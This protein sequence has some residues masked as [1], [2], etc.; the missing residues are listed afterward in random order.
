MPKTMEKRP[1]IRFTFWPTVLAVL[2]LSIFLGLGFWQL[3]RAKQKKAIQQAYDKKGLAPAI[4]LKGKVVDAGKLQFHSIVVRGTYE[5]RHQILL[6]NR[7]NNRRA[8]YHV[9]TPLKIS[10]SNTRVLINRGWIPLGLSRKELP[11]LPTPGKVVEVSGIATVPGKRFILRRPKEIIKGGWPTLWQTMDIKRFRDAVSYPV[12]PVVVLLDPG[13]KA[14]G[15]KRNWRRLDRIVSIHQG[16]AATWYTMALAV[17]VGYFL[18]A[19]RIV[20]RE[21]DAEITQRSEEE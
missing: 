16:Y 11:V 8:G 17:I 6:D 10:G 18:M 19:W 13:S 3:D 21:D 14:G 20:R 4:K 15:F 2:L 12:Q 7:I 5:T 9:I 1:V